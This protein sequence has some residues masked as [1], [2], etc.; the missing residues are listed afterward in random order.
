V[1]IATTVAAGNDGSVNGLGSPACISSAVSV[2]A[3]TLGDAIATLSNSAPYLSLLAPGVGVQSARAG[4]GTVVM[5]GTS[6]AAPHVAGAFAL[7][8]QQSPSGSMHERLD[9]LQQAG[10][11]LVDQRTGLATPRIRIFDSLGLEPITTLGVF[12]NPPDGGVISGIHAFSAWL[13][14]GRNVAFRVDDGI[15]LEAAY[16]TRRD[17]TKIVCGD[18]DNG[19]ALLFNFNLLG[20][21]EHV[22]ELL[23]DGAMLA[24]STF[25]VA[26]LGTPFLRGAPART[27]VLQDFDDKD[28]VVQWSQSAQGFMIVG[29]E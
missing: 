3:T 20:D 28:V 4:G 25:T 8:Y 13:C 27:Y 19:A 24:R 6:M 9:R 12:E 17:D 14:N 22:A 26:T 2:G 18:T 21:G 1:G 7:L 15:P 10:L 11:P 16:G 23:V 5:S 29:Y